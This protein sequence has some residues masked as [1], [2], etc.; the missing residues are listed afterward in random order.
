M[1]LLI[2]RVSEASVRVEKKVVG[3]ISSGFLIFFGTAVSDQ[4]EYTKVLAKKVIALRVFADSEGKMNRSIQEVHGELLVVSQF[5]LYADLWSGNRPS[6]IQA[7]EK[8]KALEM[9]EAFLKE[10]RSFG[11]KVETGIFGAKMEV[12][13]VN[14]GPIT[15]LLENK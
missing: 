15:F 12:S 4:L 9:Y 11:I 13:L 10:L 6:F 2:Q 1:R 8:E 5:T 3:Q 7:M 14:D